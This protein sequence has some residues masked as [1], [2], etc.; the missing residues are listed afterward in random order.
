[1]GVFE[2]S[3]EIKTLPGCTVCTVNF[4]CGGKLKTNYFSIQADSSACSNRTNTKIDIRMADSLQ[5]LISSIPSIENLPHQP[6]IEAAE[7]SLIEEAQTRMARSLD[8]APEN[9]NAIIDE[10]AEPIIRY[11]NEL[12]KLFEDGLSGMLESHICVSVTP[13]SFIVAVLCQIGFH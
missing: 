11:Y 3:E 12:K 8:Q 10:I 2:G 1:M 9:S 6:S 13:T 4:P 5:H 7:T